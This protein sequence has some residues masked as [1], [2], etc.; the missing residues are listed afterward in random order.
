[1]I[2]ATAHH[3]DEST[4]DDYYTNILLDLDIMT[5]AYSYVGFKKIN[6]AIASENLIFGRAYEDV[7]NGTIHFMKNIALPNITFRVV[8]NKEEF[9]ER[10]I[11]NIELYLSELETELWRDDPSLLKFFEV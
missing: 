8:P 5:F 1:M 10:A 7:V 11:D 9:K 4:Y 2:L 3:F 6:R